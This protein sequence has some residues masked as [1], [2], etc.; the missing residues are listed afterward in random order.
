[1]PQCEPGCPRVWVL[2]AAT[3]EPTDDRFG[4][5]GRR[6]PRR[7][8][9]ADERQRGQREVE[10]GPVRH[11]VGATPTVRRRRG[12]PTRAMYAH[13]EGETARTLLLAAALA[14]A[15]QCLRPVAR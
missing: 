15:V 2:C 12:R 8:P 4:H 5:R 14:Y 11:L 7:E 3:A 6:Q 10:E 9:A 13:A 1:M